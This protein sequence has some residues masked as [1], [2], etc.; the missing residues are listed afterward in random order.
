MLRSRTH[1]CSAL[2]A[3]NGPASPG[4]TGKMNKIAPAPRASN[5]NSHC[6]CR[7]RHW[8]TTLRPC[9]DQKHASCRLERMRFAGWTLCLDRCN[10]GLPLDTE[11][12]TMTRRHRLL[13]MVEAGLLRSRTH[14]CSSLPTGNGPVSP[15]TTGKMN[16]I[17]PAPRASNQN[18][19]CGCRSRHWQTTLRPCVDQKHASCR[20]ERMRFAG[21]TLCLDRCNSGLPLDTELRTMT[22]R[23]QEPRS[24]WKHRRIQRVLR[25]F[26]TRTIT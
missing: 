26:E 21:W 15:G 1:R 22:H 3:G 16:K 4:T 14:R 18:S 25:A 12:R 7:S 20:L 19:H 10:S 13:Q 8:Q 6:G 24:C 5:Q 23:P 2:H 9:V 11:L 17:A